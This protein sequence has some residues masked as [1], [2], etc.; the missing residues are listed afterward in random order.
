MVAL[1]NLPIRALSPI[2][3]LTTPTSLRTLRLPL[4]EGD[5]QS[6]RNP[7]SHHDPDEEEDDASVYSQLSAE[8]VRNHSQPRQLSTPTRRRTLSLPPQ[9]APG[10]LPP[11]PR[12]QV[13]TKPKLIR[14]VTP[15]PASPLLKGSDNENAARRVVIESNMAGVGAGGSL[16]QE[17]RARPIGV[18]D[19]GSPKRNSSNTHSHLDLHNVPLLDSPSTSQQPP[20]PPRSRPNSLKKRPKSYHGSGPNSIRSRPNSFHGSPSK[21]NSTTSLVTPALG[22]DTTTTPMHVQAEV[23]V[24]NPLES[25]HTSKQSARPTLVTH[26]SESSLPSRA[27]SARSTTPTKRSPR[28]RRVS[29]IFS[30][31]FGASEDKDKEHVARKLSRH[32]RKTSGSGISSSGPSPSLSSLFLSD[33][34]VQEDPIGPIQSAIRTSGTFGIRDD[35]SELSASAPGHIGSPPRHTFDRTGSGNGS[36]TTQSE[37]VK[38]ILYV[39]NV[40]STPETEEG[41]HAIGT[42]SAESREASGD[43]GQGS[44]STASDHR[45]PPYSKVTP[46]AMVGL[47]PPNGPHHLHPGSQ[48]SPELSPH[49]PS[50]GRSLSLSLNGSAPSRSNSTS[51]DCHRANILLNQ[52]RLVHTPTSTDVQHS[53]SSHLPL[54]GIPGNMVD[55][56]IQTSPQSSPAKS[57]RS[58]PLPRPPSTTTSPIATPRPTFIPPL[59]PSTAPATELPLLI[60]SHLLSTHAAAL[61]RHSSSMKEVSETMHKMARESLDWGGVLMGIAQRN[62]SVDGLPRISENQPQHAGGHEGIALP[63]PAAAFDQPDIPR[64]GTYMDYGVTPI[65]P[66]PTQDPIQQ[67]YNALNGDT[68]TPSSVPPRTHINSTQPPKPEVRR[69]KGESLPSDLLKEAQRLGDE[70]WTNLHKAEEA[71]S[72]A[73]RGLA[74]IIR[75]QAAEQSNQVEGNG[76]S[77]AYGAGIASTVPTAGD[78]SPSLSSDHVNSR[79]TMPTPLSPVSTALSYPLGSPTTA[80]RQTSMSFLPDD[81]D[82]R[83]PIPLTPSASSHSHSHLSFPNGIPQLQGHPFQNALNSVTPVLSPMM[84]TDR[85]HSQSTLKIKIRPHSTQLIPTEP[86]DYTSE[87]L[88]FASSIPSPIPGS[89]PLSSSAG[90]DDGRKKMT[91]SRSTMNSSSNSPHSHGH[92]QNHASGGGSTIKGTGTG[93]GGRKL[94]KKQ[95]PPP[96]SSSSKTLGTVGGSGSASAAGSFMASENGSMKRNKHWWNRRK[97]E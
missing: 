76:E 57:T 59:P 55:E 74:D 45:T 77:A 29:S 42:K 64:S 56:S 81:G 49:D 35:G 26:Q 60:A 62:E 71:W 63:K 46:I 25:G 1:S 61:L 3:E 87:H 18:I 9:P 44:H 31:I 82:M 69:R 48:L 72:E 83:S 65:A 67:A 52:G 16:S 68:P 2:T 43:S 84:E 94:A 92:G 6:E 27:K 17:G 40:V 79:Y 78:Y 36:I 95:P 21:G 86:R 93:T 13:S 33:S 15:P 88:G 34:P 8:T 47:L 89:A 97:D 39:E 7:L 85:D 30:S 10:G 4:D 96:P 53:S 37:G 80:H 12:A 32:S 20:T 90:T 58:R 19:G 24:V 5:Y 51:S 73:M 66:I 38:R 50:L 23:L 14:R 70:G 75:S 41:E 28:R 22:L 54:S 91:P 11:P